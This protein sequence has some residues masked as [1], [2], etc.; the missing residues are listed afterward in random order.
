MPKSKKAPGAGVAAKRQ[1]GGG[2][3]K[4][5]SRPKG[6]GNG[7]KEP[8]AKSAKPSK[9]KATGNAGTKNCTIPK[10]ECAKGK[11]RLADVLPLTV[12]GHLIDYLTFEQLISIT[13]AC[14]RI[15]GA[16]GRIDT[17]NIMKASELDGDDDYY[18]RFSNI[19]HVNIGCTM[20]LCLRKHTL[21]PEVTARIVPFLKL[22][23]KLKGVSIWTGKYTPNRGNY[24]FS[25][26]YIPRRKETN[27]TRR[28]PQHPN[29]DN[30]MKALLM[31]FSEAFEAGTLPADLEV[32]TI[33][34]NYNCQSPNSDF[35]SSSGCEV[36]R[37]ICKSFP[38]HEIGNIKCSL[39]FGEEHEPFQFCLGMKPLLNIMRERNGWDRFV[40]E[41]YQ[42][43]LQMIEAGS[44]DE[45]SVEERESSEHR[46]EGY[47]GVDEEEA[48]L[49]KVEL[50]KKGFILQYEP[51][52]IGHITEEARKS[53]EAFITDFD[54]RPQIIPCMSL[55]H[56][57][58][59]N[60]CDDWSPK[61]KFL[62][63]QET[64]RWLVSQG[65]QVDEKILVG[66][67][68]DDWEKLNDL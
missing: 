46:I 49:L 34:E 36:C 52:D 7:G 65:F 4:P 58:Y 28:H 47:F 40:A 6:N 56:S 45:S 44:F 1:Q 13:R 14:K 59:W 25:G 66:I 12:I 30:V 27:I 57:I 61:G 10:Y 35:Q 2:N 23:P 68:R 24:H 39:G 63:D 17:L 9:S 32:G 5:K 62:I 67:T 31:S 3:K 26:K 55:V 19:T 29:N 53:I 48:E 42:P 8:A 16:V 11:G 41:S 21:M 60:G 20:D 54:L 37:A 50:N 22:F 15:R 64:L 18:R 51:S 33:L 43:L 38:L